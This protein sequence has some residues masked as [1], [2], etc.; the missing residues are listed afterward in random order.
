MKGYKCLIWKVGRCALYLNLQTPHYQ[1]QTSY[2]LRMESIWRLDPMT[3]LS[4]CGGYRAENESIPS[5][6]THQQSEA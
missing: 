5:Q 1:P 4:E 6:D 2:F 3:E